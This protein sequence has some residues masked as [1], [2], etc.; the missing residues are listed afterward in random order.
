MQSVLLCAK[1]NFPC[2]ATHH[3]QNKSKMRRPILLYSKS[4][5]RMTLFIQSVGSRVYETNWGENI[6]GGGGMY[7]SFSF[8]GLF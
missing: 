3:L 6:I 2:F 8:D 1:K 5:T 4:G 7:A